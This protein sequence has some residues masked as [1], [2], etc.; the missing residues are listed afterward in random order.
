MRN[1]RVLWREVIVS[2][3]GAFINKIN[4]PEST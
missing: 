1:L 2:V 4:K 3:T